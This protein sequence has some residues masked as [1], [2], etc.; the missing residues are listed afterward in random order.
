M[1]W[2]RE[3][4]GYL[5]WFI[6]TVT[7]AYAAYLLRVWLIARRI[8]ATTKGL[9]I[10][11][12][13][14]IAYVGLIIVAILGPLYGVVEQEATI[15]G[16]DIW[17]LM[18]ISASMEAADVPPSRL[19]RAKSF[20]ADL[21]AAQ[22]GNRIGIIAFSTEAFVQCPLT[23]DKEALNLFLQTL[24]PA[25]M[26][27]Q[28]SNM[29]APLT[30]LADVLEQDTNFRNTTARCAL[31]ISDGETEADVNKPAARLIAMRV[32]IFV[33]G[34]GTLDGAP[35]PRKRKAGEEPPISV[36]QPTFLKNLAE[37]C[38][39]EYFWLNP[40]ENPLEAVLAEISKVKSKLFVAQTVQLGANKYHFAL[41]LA[42]L[43]MVFDV[44]F[45]IGVI[46][47]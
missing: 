11:F 32:P 15:S 9:Y 13:I 27:E 26:P 38:H 45:T 30:V 16:K 31:L 23:S 8:N 24:S 43:L 6:G 40:T 20:V 37:A 18:D 47:W 22:P 4:G 36:L 1:Q 14:R 44:V 34:V 5:Q 39:G 2:L 7:F 25:I 21:A 29:E 41:A 3:S 42:L 19:D 33:L 12:L 17:V 28:G 46:K 35:L 10:K